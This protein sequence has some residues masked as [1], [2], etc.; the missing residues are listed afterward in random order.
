MQA[1]K[2][3]NH[4]VVIGASMSGMLAARVAADH[5]D[6][7]TLI[8]RDDLPM[9]SEPLPRKGLP[10]ARH[11]HLLLMRGRIILDRLFPGFTAELVA[12]GA[13]KIDVI[14]DVR[15]YSPVGW[16]IRF[17]SGVTTPAC[18]RDLLDWVVR[19]RLTT[20][21]QIRIMSNTEV[22]E[23]IAS[24]D[25]RRVTGVRVRA[26]NKELDAVQDIQADFVVDASGRNSHTPQWLE[27][28][29]YARPT[30]KVVSAFTGYASRIYTKPTDV[31]W[32]GLL[33]QPAPPHNLRGGVIYALEGSR[34]V[35]TLAGAGKDY[36]PTD[37][38]E[39][40][41]FAKTLRDP[42]LYNT[43]Q[44]L[45]PLSPINGYRATENRCRQY[46]RLPRWPEGLVVTGD[47]ACAFNPVYGQGMTAAALGAATLSRCLE[48]HK[49]SDLR[50]VGRG[51]QHHLARVNATIWLLATGEDFR[52]VQTESSRPRTLITKLLHRYVDLFIPQAA[53]DPKLYTRLAEVLHLVQPPI[54]LL[55]PEY[56]WRTIKLAGK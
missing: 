4:A 14:G 44:K 36:P 45:Q 21:P 2:K 32:Q 53:R 35:V 26:R 31:D 25:K 42:L 8:D 7:V 16:A 15:W 37:E 49:G 41:E 17:K 55:N 1:H 48:Q 54:S 52:Y 38:T 3:Y 9:G 10:Q 11:V 33:M 46:E 43:I 56:L 24:G 51:F 27:Q 34:C 18:S 5:F 40:M 6:R 19:C 30:E 20:Y 22:V 39:F 23:L 47:A 29:G 28:L 13:Q 50:G 12:H